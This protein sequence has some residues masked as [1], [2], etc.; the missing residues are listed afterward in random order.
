MQ[1]KILF[2]EA[3][4]KNHHFFSQGI[5][6][7]VQHRFGMPKADIVVYFCSIVVLCMRLTQS[8]GYHKCVEQEYTNKSILP[9]ECIIAFEQPLLGTAFM[10]KFRLKEI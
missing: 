4:K 7:L 6:I 1:Q 10:A 9:S 3:A 5:T 8:F 2:K